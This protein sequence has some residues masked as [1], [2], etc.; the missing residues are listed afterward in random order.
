MGGFAAAWI[1][2]EG[3]VIWRNVHKFH[4]PPVP[5]QLLGVTLLFAALGIVAD[6]VPAAAST[7]TVLAWGLNVAGILNAWPKGLGG[8]A[9]RVVAEQEKT[10][11][12]G[13][14]AT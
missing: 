8:Q 6:S 14:T 3:I 2:G 4:K 5:G 12:E 13:V 11:A 9:A 1:V 7:V 10:Q